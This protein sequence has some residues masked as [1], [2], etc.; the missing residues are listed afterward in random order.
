V[1]AALAH[2]HE[3]QVLEEATDFGRFED[4]DRAHAQATATF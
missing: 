3:T 2:G 4:R 1:R